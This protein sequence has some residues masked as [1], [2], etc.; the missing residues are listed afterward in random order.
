MIGLGR[1]GAATGTRLAEHGHQVTGY[2]RDPAKAERLSDGAQ[3]ADN[4]ENLVDCP[5]L[6][7]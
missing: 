5:N 7:A 2:D 6:A 1:M 4:L 3:F